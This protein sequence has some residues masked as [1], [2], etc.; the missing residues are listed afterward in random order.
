MSALA[1]QA[2]MNQKRREDNYNKQQKVL[3]SQKDY[4]ASQL[5]GIANSDILYY[6]ILVHNNN[7]GFDDNGKPTNTNTSIPL[8]FNETRSQPYVNCAD[9]YFMSVV[10]FD[11][12][13]SSLPVFIPEPIVGSSP[14]GTSF[15]TIYSFYING[16]KSVVTWTPANTSLYIPTVAPANYSS[17]EYF[18][19][20]SYNYFLSLLN[21]QM[22]VAFGGGSPFLTYDKANVTI[23]GSLSDWQTDYLGSGPNTL[24]FNP[25]LYNLFS[26]LPAI[27]QP[28]GNYQIL[29][30]ANPSGLNF[31]NVPTTASITPITYKAVAS[32]TEF[33]PFPIWNPVETILFVT[34]LMPVVSELVA[35][36][37]VYGQKIDNTV[38]PPPNNTLPPS[39]EKTG[40][41]VAFIGSPTNY[42]ISNAGVQ[43]ILTD[44][45]SPQNYGIEYK[46][47]I[48]YTPIAE[49]RLTDL[50]DEKAI[51][52]LD[53]EVYWKDYLGEIH[54]FLLLSGG[55]ANLKIM[56]RK[57]DFNTQ[58]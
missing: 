20:Y 38:Y 22:N 25:A 43:N 57:K 44:F 45:A 10:R 2:I 33:T 1:V 30:V 50:Y 14:N 21:G 35:K 58:Y 6:N 11:V 53:I 52:D 18:Y 27:K 40:A 4:K 17:Y 9:N 15:D 37:L 26:S 56:F 49:F 32:S 7:T 5:G 34:N 39:Y 36:P 16:I 8:V 41:N 23:T 55:T 3:Q 46:P 47:S 42:S 13:T 24:S 28:D 54:P 19:C 12:D 29:F 31:V 48:S 51:R